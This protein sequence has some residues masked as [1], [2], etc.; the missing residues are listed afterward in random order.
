[1]TESQFLATPVAFL[2]LFRPNPS[3]ASEHCPAIQNP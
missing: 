1:M 3:A 2:D